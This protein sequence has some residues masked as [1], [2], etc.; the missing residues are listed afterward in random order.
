MDTVKPNYFGAGSLEVSPA[1]NP[2]ETGVRR[3]AISCDALVTQPGPG[4][5]TLPDI[6][7]HAA[8]NYGQEVQA[9][10]WRDVIKVHEEVKEVH[11]HKKTWKYQELS[12]YRYMNYSQLKDAITET[13]R[14]LIHLGINAGDVFNVYSQTSVNWQLAAQACAYISTTIATAY[15]TLGPEG[16]LHSL[17][18]PECVGLF[19]NAGLFN[20][21][22]SVIENAPSVKL[23]IYDG[24]PD[25]SLLS[26][27]STA[28]RKVISLDEVRE[29][30]RPISLDVLADRR[31]T[32][33]T[34]ACIIYT[35]GSTGAP[36]GVCHNHSSLIAGVGSVKIIFGHHF[37]KGNVYLAYLP[38][39]H[40]L[41][42][43]VELCA[44]FLGVTMGYGTAR[45]LSDSGVKN[46]LGDIK[47]LRPTIM[48]GVPAVWENIR[49]GIL[50]NVEK[51]GWVAKTVFNAAYDLKKNH[52]P[53]LGQLAHDTVFKGVREATGG[54]LRVIMN[55]GAAVSKE[56][57][58]FLSIAV[59]EMLQGYGM[60]ESCGMCALQPPELAEYGAT[61]V[62][63]PVP[64]LEIKLVDIPDAGY[65]ASSTPPEGEILIR[66]P[67]LTPGYF[68]RPDLNNDPE[69]FTPDGWFRTGD[70]GRWTTEGCLA[71]I[72]RVKNLVKL[73]QGEYI[74]L[75]HLEAIYKSCN[76]ISNIC[77]HVYE[78]KKLVGIVIP[79][80]QHIRSALP[81]VSKSSL[82]D[83]CDS[84]EV[85]QAVLQALLDKAKE[86][87]LRGAELFSAVVLTP[88]EWTVD[89]GLVTA[90]QK[91]K[92][93]EVGKRFK[94]EVE[95]VCA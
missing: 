35:S 64:S 49:K 45:T 4:I 27:L 25:Q 34:L 82:P 66:G 65:R 95:R 94:D 73:E 88:E 12:D 20:T 89:N 36:K 16:L 56:T 61:I 62:G 92:R 74:A 33:S 70:V 23:V 46:C 52:V 86:N 87:K 18:E 31:P 81:S 1:A 67:S 24:K 63:L 13:A 76:L 50:S 32:A 58:D 44:I 59:V 57:R 3:C 30:G 60:T 9:V 37:V 48:F 72:D 91:I 6:I 80:E 17:N 78:G 77:V 19:T 29:L 2:N 55:G 42:F 39:A 5:E 38:L 51:G 22:A 84:E 15:D 93:N 40:A 8:R 21:L 11:G 71:V 68:K 83:I 47:T 54:R 85:Q 7:D 69:I 14:G 28:D 26:K 53:I 79:H 75:E 43:M 10:G 41:E 90:A